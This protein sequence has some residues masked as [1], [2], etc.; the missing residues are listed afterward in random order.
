[1]GKDKL[2][3]INTIMKNSFILLLLL[4]FVT[5]SWA[6]ESV[7]ELITKGLNAE[8]IGLGSKSYILIEIDK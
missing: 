3:T 6:Q 8:K 4:S 5:L 7:D 2:K 1:M